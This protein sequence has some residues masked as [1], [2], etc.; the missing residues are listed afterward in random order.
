MIITKEFKTQFLA[1]SASN[2]RGARTRAKISY[3]YGLIAT[4]QCQPKF[5]MMREIQFLKCYQFVGLNCLVV[6]MNF[7]IEIIEIISS[8]ISLHFYFD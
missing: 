3:W 4:C 8:W 2:L 6:N 7:L 5:L 1:S